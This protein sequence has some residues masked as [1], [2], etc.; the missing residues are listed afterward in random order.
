MTGPGYVHRLFRTF[1]AVDVDGKISAEPATV[2]VDDVDVPA[3]EIAFAGGVQ[4]VG[5][6]M[7]GDDGGAFVDVVAAS[8]E[9]AQAVWHRVVASVDLRDWL[10]NSTTVG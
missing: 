5:V 7:Y 10:P 4:R 8:A 3:A 1:G 9:V 2:V 6:T